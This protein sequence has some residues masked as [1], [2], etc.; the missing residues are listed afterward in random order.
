MGRPRN[1]EIPPDLAREFMR[2]LRPW[3]EPQVTTLGRGRP[4]SV[5]LREHAERY[6]RVH[7]VT[8]EAWKKYFATDRDWFIAPPT[9]L[10]WELVDGEAPQLRAP[11]LARLEARRRPAPAA[12]DPEA[13]EE[14]FVEADRY[15]RGDEW[16]KVR[17]I[18]GA[19]RDAALAGM[20]SYPKEQR[21]VVLRARTG[22]LFA[23]TAMPTGAVLE[24]YA[25]RDTQNELDE[26]TGILDKLPRLDLQYHARFVS[27]QIVEDTGRFDQRLFHD[28]RL[29]ART[30]EDRLALEAALLLREAVHLAK[31]RRQAALYFLEAAH[32]VAIKSD[33]LYLMVCTL[34][35][36]AVERARSTHELY[37]ALEEIDGALELAGDAAHAL[38][39]CRL[40]LARALVLVASGEDPR[41]D[42]EKARA[43]AAAGCYV[44][45]LWKLKQLEVFRDEFERWS[46]RL[47]PAIATQR[48]AM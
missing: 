37:P 5:A 30:R 33:D 35:D 36:V 32:R 13:L 15:G 24:P 10:L 38:L 23:S 12:V 11:F 39:K 9:K 47:H 31:N 44:H 25:R 14:Q 20:R 29:R 22:L 3:L 21:F 26:V 46:L 41:G 43:L 19:M 4:P 17:L 1:S 16:G 40:Y 27:L 7:S 6:R 45:Q 48:G 28:L 34:K 2:E 42:A 8:D 18:A